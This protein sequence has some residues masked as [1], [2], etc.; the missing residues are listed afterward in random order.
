MPLD[1][2][3]WRMEQEDAGKAVFEV[4][5]WNKNWG[6]NGYFLAFFFLVVLLASAWK[7]FQPQAEPTENIG[8][9]TT[10]VANDA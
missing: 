5:W 1:T 6:G 7:A 2:I 8:E 4:E 9:K 10:T 3:A